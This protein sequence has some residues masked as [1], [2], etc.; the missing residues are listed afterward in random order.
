[1]TGW[2]PRF[3]QHRAHVSAIR[4]AALAAVDPAAAVRAHLAASDWADAARI[5]IV[6]AG[7]AGVPM[8]LAAAELIGPRLTAGVVVV[9]HMPGPEVAV[10]PTLSFVEGGHP[11]PTTGS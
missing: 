6:G 7:K 11:Q 5:Y 1:M 4:G 2:G 10:P 3:E 9:P 8:A